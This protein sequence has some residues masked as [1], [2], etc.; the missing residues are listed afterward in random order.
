MTC[1]T[2]IGYKEGEQIRSDAVQNAARIR[3]AVA[4]VIAIDNAQQ[5]I[6]GYNK[7]HA[8]AQR[9]V[10]ISER[11][12]WRLQSVFWPRELDFLAEFANPGP[13]TISTKIPQYYAGMLQASVLAK[14]GPEYQKIRC[15]RGR[16]QKSQ[17]Q[18]NL[19]D[20]TMAMSSAYNNARHMG[21]DVS[22]LEKFARDDRDYQR[23]FQAIAMGRGLL[24]A[25]AGIMAA[26]AKALNAASSSYAGRFNSAMEALGSAYGRTQASAD[27]RAVWKDAYKRSTEIPMTANQSD[28]YS[29]GYGLKSYL[30]EQSVSFTPSTQ[31]EQSM[32][33]VG[34]ISGGGTGGL[35]IGG[36]MGGQGSYSN[37]NYMAQSQQINNGYVGNRDRVRTGIVSFP[38]SYGY[39]DVDIDQFGFAFADDEQVGI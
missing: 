13:N 7:Q 19:S 17:Y 2:D 18:K 16:Y 28:P 26:G 27:D 6:D 9:S 31:V 24:Q 8:I 29:Q 38:L 32:A 21:F 25:A 4:L 22:R 37:V 33:G 14:F 1:M 39:V 5:V 11:Q 10:N 12:Q 35:G 30:A 36:V 34:G 23:R 3:Q 15:S 20:V